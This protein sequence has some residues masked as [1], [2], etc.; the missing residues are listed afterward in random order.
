MAYDKHQATA[1][2]HPLE[3]ELRSQ[4]PAMA[5]V[6]A[7]A[8]GLDPADQGGGGRSADPDPRRRLRH[9]GV[10]GAAPRRRSRNAQVWG[11][12]LVAGMLAKG[13]ERWRRHAG[14]VQPVQGDSERL[15]FAD[16][17]VR[18]RHLRQQLPSLPAPGP[19]RRRDAPGAPAGRPA[20]ARST[21]TATP[22]GAGSSTTSASRGSKGTST[23]PRRS[24]FRELFAQA[25]LRAVAQRVYRGP[26]PFLLT[27][28]VAA[29]PVSAI[30]SPHFLA[31]ADG[32][33]AGETD[34][35]ASKRPDDA[36]PTRA[37]SWQS[38]SRR[39]SLSDQ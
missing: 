23:T 18:R 37:F 36:E 13:A 24:R 21:A 9:R 19:R 39:K 25:G 26:A 11:I 29:E 5:A 31:T 6:R 34:R 4:H 33:R 14:H 30:P 1:R 16:G 28:A 20:D 32:P 27:E 22:P 15:P 35:T 3:R 17:D 38:A 2:I 8:P 12:D 7:V 10:R